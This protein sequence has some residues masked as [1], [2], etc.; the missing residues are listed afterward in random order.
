ML[1][2][3]LLGKSLREIPTPAAVLDR[4][5]VERNCKGMLE[6]CK[7]LGVD[8]RAHVKSHKVGILLKCLPAV[9]C[10]KRKFGR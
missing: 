8:F 1:R 10:R 7:E 5:I 2:E 4:T 3:S 9:E 6:A